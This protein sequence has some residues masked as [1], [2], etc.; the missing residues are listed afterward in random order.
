[1]VNLVDKLPSP[2]SRVPTLRCLCLSAPSR[3]VALLSKP[4]SQGLSGRLRTAT[5]LLVALCAAVVVS[6][7]SATPAFPLSTS[8][9]WIVDSTGKRVKFACA[10]WS[11]G[12]EKV[13][14]CASSCRRWYARLR[15]LFSQLQ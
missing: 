3:L 8:S 5:L 7:K 14:L 10:N 9:R 13:S 2:E 1:M 11:G 6:T 15:S 4:P 12:E